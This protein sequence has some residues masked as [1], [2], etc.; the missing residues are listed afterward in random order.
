MTSLFQAKTKKESQKSNEGHK[1]LAK[2]LPKFAQLGLFNITRFQ[3]NEAD[4]EATSLSKNAV[5]HKNCFS[6]Y[7]QY[8]MIASNLQPQRKVEDLTDLIVPMMKVIIP[9]QRDVK[10]E[11]FPW[12]RLFAAFVVKTIHQATFVLLG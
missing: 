8:I 3:C 5:Y 12:V 6:R 10:E 7:D 11:V 2:M 4:L 1:T 9:V